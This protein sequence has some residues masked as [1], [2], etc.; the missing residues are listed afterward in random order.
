M[1]TTRT[2]SGYASPSTARRPEILRASLSGISPAYTAAALLI[3]SLQ[4]FSTLLISS[5]AMGLSCEKSKR[6]LLG[7][8]REPFWVA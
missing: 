4:I 1:E 6:S 3:Q 2:G 5:T 8:T 7:A